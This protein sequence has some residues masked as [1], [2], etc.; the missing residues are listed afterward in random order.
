MTT[1]RR[2]PWR[3][4]IPQPPWVPPGWLLLALYALLLLLLALAHPGPR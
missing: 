3:H 4:P 1:P 2:G